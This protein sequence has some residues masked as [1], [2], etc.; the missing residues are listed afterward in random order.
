MGASRRARGRLRRH[1]RDSGGAISLRVADGRP[2]ARRRGR[3]DSGGA[4]SL[5]VADGR[6]GVGRRGRDES[7][8]AISL[9][10]VLMVPVSAFAAVVALAGPQ[11]MAAES[12][13]Q[14]AADDLA[15]LAVAWRD[16]QGAEPGDMKEGPLHAFWPD[17]D[18]EGLTTHHDAKIAVIED[19]IQDYKERID[20][21]PDGEPLTVEELREA[22]DA[23]EGLLTSE[24]RDRR[25]LRADW[26]RA[27]E[28]MVDSLLRDLGYL[29]VD[30]N[31]LRGFYSDSLKMSGDEDVAE[32]PCQS[33]D[34]IVVQDAVHVALA[35]NWRDAGWAAAQVWPDGTRVA[36]ESVG[37]ISQRD[38]SSTE[39]DCDG[40]L[41]VLDER[42]RPVLEPAARSRVLSR[43]VPR[44]LLA[45]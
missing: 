11:R 29:G 10:V 40:A 32:L 23:Q 2:G 21:P 9:W 38:D 43:S 14:D 26:K 36:A 17:C 12:T 45:G 15:M 22:R 20:D 27:C 25:E 19:S 16:G 24:K 39:E 31:S 30:V 7:G 18:T 4:I 13:V 42:G 8:G 41:T 6:P 33:S 34:G 3:D 28:L 35:A 1:R 44:T 5:W 37:R